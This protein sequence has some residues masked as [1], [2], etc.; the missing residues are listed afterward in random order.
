MLTGEAK[1][2]V[3][4]QVIVVGHLVHYGPQTLHT[5]QYQLQEHKHT[6]TTALEYTKFVC[7]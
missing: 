3:I 5:A 7:G 6:D 2:A 4:D 1:V